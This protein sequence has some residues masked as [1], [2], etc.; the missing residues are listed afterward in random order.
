MAQLRLP[1]TLGLPDFP[2]DTISRERDLANSHPGGI[3]DLS[4]GTPVD[5]TPESVQRALRDAADAPGYPL[6]VG[7]PE[8]KESILAWA[9]RRGLVDLPETA[10]IPTTGS[11]EIV[12]WLPKMLGVGP[13]DSVLYPA[14]AYP[15]YHVGAVLAQATGIPFSRV[16]AN[17]SPLAERPAML[18]LNSPSNPTG[19]VMSREEMRTAVRWAREHGAVVVSDEC[20][21]ALP[22]SA[23]YVD[24]GVPSA[25][26]PYVC[27]G[28]PSGILV[29]YSLSKQSNMAGYRGAVLL[30]DPCLMDAVIEARKHGG[31]M[32]PTPV[33][34]AIS[35]ALDDEEAVRTQREKYQIRRQSMM[36]AVTGAGL[37]LD[38]KTE[39]GL[40][41]W[42]R[43]GTG[44]SIH[45]LDIAGHANEGRALVHW[46]A[47]RGILVAPGDFY[48]ADSGDFV[49]LALT[50]TDERIEEA[51]SRLA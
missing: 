49:R 32:V 34:A 17:M 38:P 46:F 37:A 35:A 15:T 21:A 13:G 8:V 41:L 18:W 50:A 29:A 31:M 44:R 42:L 14:V 16:E 26:D 24:S 7:T 6:V 19:E 27:D 20:Y 28:D 9:R 40:Y 39:A 3:V 36:R 48:G 2:W 25:L 5:P 10:V 43:R 47:K 12:A 11:K 45:D 33:Q 4:V 51:C 30:G 23:R 22:W 1:R